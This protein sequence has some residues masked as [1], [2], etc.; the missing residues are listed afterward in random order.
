[1][2]L[3]AFGVAAAFVFAHKTPSPA[4]GQEFEFHTTPP[5]SYSFVVF[6]R[7]APVTGHLAPQWRPDNTRT[8]C[9]L[10]LFVAVKPWV[11][12][13]VEG[14]RAINQGGVP[15]VRLASAVRRKTIEL[16]NTCQAFSH[17]VDW[18]AFFA[19]VFC[20]NEESFDTCLP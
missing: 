5:K 17:L 8:Q 4:S 11:Q 12:G 20:T 16:C 14:N 15:L 3:H 1:M 9:G 2:A 19:M 18:I 7:S 13:K 6:R 10:V